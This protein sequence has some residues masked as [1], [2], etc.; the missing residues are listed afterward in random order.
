MVDECPLRIFF[1]AF[2]SSASSVT[3]AR[4]AEIRT[5][6]GTYVRAAG[7][8]FAPPARRPSSCCSPTSMSLKRTAKKK[9]I[10]K[11]RTH[12]KD[13]GS[14]QVQIAILS[15]GVEKL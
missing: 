7:C 1:L 2:P 8:V 11:H 14:P 6:F 9:L 12:A 15:R 5:L 4:R 3:L 10:E 13:T